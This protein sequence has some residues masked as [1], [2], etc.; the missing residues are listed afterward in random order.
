MD[1]KQTLNLPRT[2]FPMKANLPQLEPEI[3]KFWQQIDLYRHVQQSNTGKP[4][5]ILHDG[6]PYANGDIHLGHTLNKVLK[7]MIVK[8]RSMSGYDAP[9]VPGWD[10]H[11]LPIEQQAIKNLALNRRQTDVVEF[12]NRCR[13]YALHFVQVQG[14]QFQRLGVRGDWEKP[15]L[16]LEPDFEAEQVG[17]FGQM[18]MKGFIYKGLKPVYWCADCETALAEAEV[19]YQAKR[20]PS[21]YVAFP[22][23]DAR[24]LFEA[25]G[26][27][28][29]IWTTT[30]W[31]LPANLAIALHPQISYVL[32]QEG[33]RCFLV[34]EELLGQVGATLGWQSPQVTGRWSGQEL[35]GVV[36]HHPLVDRSS[37]LI[38]GEHVTLE[39]GTGCVHTAP[40]HGTEDFE[41]GRK[42]DLPVLS[43]VDHQGR[44]TSE[45]GSLN[46]LHYNE[47]NKVIT[48][49]LD[50]DQK[51][52]R[53]SFVEHQ[54][55]HCWRCKHPVFFRA[56]PQWFASIDGFRTEALAEIDRVQW[57]P[58]WGRDRIYNMVEGRSDWCISR[59]RTWGVPIPI[60]Y[61][62]ECDTAVYSEAT[63]DRIQALFREHGSNCWFSKPV[64]ELIPPGLT[65]PQCGAGTFRRETDIMDVWFDSGSSHAAVLASRPD[66]AW[67]ADLYLEGSDQHRGWFNSSLS[68]AVATRGQAPYRAVLTHGF[69]VDEEGKKMSKSMGNGID[70][71]EVC[72]Q[73]GADILRLWVSAADYRRDVAASP[74]IMRQMT[75]AYRKIRNTCRFILSNL[76]DFEPQ[77]DAVRYD[78]L[79]ELDQW[80]LLKLH[81]V[82]QQVTE[83]YE[84]YEFH[85]VYHRI[86]DFCAVE[87]SAFYLDV[88]KDRLYSLATSDPRRRAT[89][90]VLAQIIEA[91]VRLLAPVLSFT[92]EEIW[93]YLPP[94][95]DR[96]VSVQL[97]PWPQA[98]QLYLAD[99]LEQRWDG[100][101]QL[102]QEVTRALEL[103]RQQKAIGATTQAAVELY[104]D[105]DLYILAD[106]VD[107]LA[108]LLIVAQVRLA[109][110][111]RPV[112]VGAY[113]GIGVAVVI[114]RATG[115]KC[116]RCW[117]YSSTVGMNDQHPHLCQRCLGVL[118]GD[119][120]AQ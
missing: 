119:D 76:Y 68:T 81:R 84:R 118:A 45:G 33:E 65:C 15:Y 56:T 26:A 1:Y 2:Q 85:V 41:V 51:L 43:P 112:P 14:E 18:A 46:G 70:P 10:T 6:P 7:D 35:E 93:R 49:A 32:V 98:D 13:D 60:F 75:E 94:A 4:K 40:G 20:S 92:A 69:L 5:F 23:T 99:R 104:L 109:A 82:I 107:N 113:Q 80:A 57:I 30:P 36:T 63:F 115:Q 29:I 89:Q 116:E 11:G 34:A 9:Y 44:F 100:I 53:L 61:C 28:V 24:G 62:Q 103:A 48:A 42:Y 21:I 47:A 74:G 17:V 90:T 52:L 83:A 19:E 106:Q 67:P 50:Q 110:P 120:A 25:N 91:L 88:I 79:P 97:A 59:Q 71:L 102:R 12:R 27:Y 54:Y 114:E 64:A 22:V 66:L 95:P 101:L 73:M 31:T 87:M 96:P 108:E 58:A 55:P 72:Q 38:L 117:N 77:F 111:G 3:L 8:Y 16:T 39:Q 86:H 37:P 78:E 105:E